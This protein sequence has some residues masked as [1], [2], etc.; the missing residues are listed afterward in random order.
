MY[1]RVR[2]SGYEN[3]V[4]WEAVT[5]PDENGEMAEI[6]GEI[7]RSHNVPTPGDA[8][9][10]YRDFAGMEELSTKEREVFVLTYVCLLWPREVADY[11]RI[12]VEAVKK[13]LTRARHKLKLL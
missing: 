8:L 10:E 12:D 5:T 4:S 11:L 7:V 9:A 13:R 3:E 1:G 2:T 6:N